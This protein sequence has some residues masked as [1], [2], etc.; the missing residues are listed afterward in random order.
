MA[1]ECDVLLGNEAVQIREHPIFLYDQGSLKLLTFGS[2]LVA[3][4]SGE[5]VPFLI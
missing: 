1:A 5:L 4:L 2:Q 3:F